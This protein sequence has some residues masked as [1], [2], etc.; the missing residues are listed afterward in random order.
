MGKIAQYLA[1]AKHK[2]WAV[3]IIFGMYC[4]NTAVISIHSKKIL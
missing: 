2:K 1:T 3:C 4:M